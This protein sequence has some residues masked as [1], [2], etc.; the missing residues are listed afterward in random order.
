[1]IGPSGGGGGYG[2]QPSSGIRVM[3]REIR[4][5]LLG[6]QNSLASDDIYD[7]LPSFVKNEANSS[8]SRLA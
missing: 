6:S 5:G 3:I 7:K 1:M 8:A 4:E 2:D